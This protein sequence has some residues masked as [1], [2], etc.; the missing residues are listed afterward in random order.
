MQ[1]TSGACTMPRLSY[2]CLLGYPL[3]RSM[4]VRERR[5]TRDNVGPADR[6][7]LTGYLVDPEGRAVPLAPLPM[8][9]YRF[10]SA[11]I[12]LTT[13]TRGWGGLWGETTVG[14]LGGSDGCNCSTAPM[15]SNHPSAS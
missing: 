8:P 9:S 13:G 6:P 12:D 1:P 11:L 7:G 3:P 10:H 15:I 14:R 2:A 5:F 4:P